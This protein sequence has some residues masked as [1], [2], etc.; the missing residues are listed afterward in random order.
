MFCD[1]GLTMFKKIHSFLIQIPCYLLARKLSNS[2][3]GIYKL[4]RIEWSVANRVDGLAKFLNAEGMHDRSALLKNH[5]IQEEAHA[6]LLENWLVSRGYSIDRMR[7]QGGLLFFREDRLGKNGY[8]Y[9]YSIHTHPVVRL[10]LQR[11]PLGERD[12]KEQIIAYGYLERLASLTYRR[13]ASLAKGDLRSLLQKIA[14]DE[15]N[16][17]S[18]LHYIKWTGQVWGKPEWSLVIPFYHILWFFLSIIGIWLIS[19]WETIV[20]Y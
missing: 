18:Y 13:M 8:Q 14:D 7:R 15:T 11:K 5:A 2:S 20:R 10:F 1:L 12:Y 9:P 19:I 4:S 16:H 6:R 3:G 17:A